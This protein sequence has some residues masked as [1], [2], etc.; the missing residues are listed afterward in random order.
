VL[1]TGERFAF[2]LGSNGMGSCWPALYAVTRLHSAEHSSEILTGKARVVASLYRLAADTGI[3]VVERLQ[4]L[5]FFGLD[6][7]NS[8]RRH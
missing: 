3:D 1:G 7:I 8:L 4:R 5:S 2:T 6:Q